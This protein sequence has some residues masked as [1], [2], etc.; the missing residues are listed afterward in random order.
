MQ[1]SSSDTTGL[2]LQTGKKLELV[3]RDGMFEV[4]PKIGVQI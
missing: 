1:E 2:L 4:I 3:W